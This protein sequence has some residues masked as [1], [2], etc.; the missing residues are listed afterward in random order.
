MKTQSHNTLP[1]LR[2]AYDSLDDLG[3]VINRTRV[4]VFRKLLN[5]SFTQREKE[6]IS[7]DLISRGIETGVKE[8]IEKYFGG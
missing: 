6:L 1:E 5:E 3:R 2:R 4:T 8:T 7:N